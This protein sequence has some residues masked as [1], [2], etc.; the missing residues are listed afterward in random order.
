MRNPFRS[1]KHTYI[2]VQENSLSLGTFIS[3]ELRLLPKPQKD[4]LKA[5]F[6]SVI[7][8]LDGEPYQVLPPQYPGKR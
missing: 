6:E 7:T 5:F 1:S 8:E 2:L 4:M 3:P